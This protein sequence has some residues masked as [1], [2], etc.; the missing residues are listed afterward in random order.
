LKYLIDAQLPLHLK[1]YLEYYNID[2][3]HLLELDPTGTMSDA[4][5]SKLADIQNR[6]VISKDIDFYNS[7]LINNSPKNYC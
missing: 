7:H 5:M 1:K 2:A 4:S 3:L 6:V